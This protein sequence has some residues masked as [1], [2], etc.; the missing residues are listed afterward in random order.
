MHVQ[1]F[2]SS[3]QSKHVRL[4]RK[5][6]W[7][8]WHLQPVAT[9]A[10]ETVGVRWVLLVGREKEFCFNQRH[11][12]KVFDQN[13]FGTSNRRFWGFGEFEEVSASY[14]FYFAQGK[15]ILLLLLPLLLSSFFSSSLFSSFCFIQFC[16]FLLRMRHF[17]V[18]GIWIRIRD[19]WFCA[20]S[21]NTADVGMW[22]HLAPL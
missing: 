16:R 3:F 1:R 10:M 12:C 18:L 17:N 11:R 14:T 2:R 15:S 13:T 8:H 20:D 9:V 6:C 19:V 4:F 22:I 7:H 21:G 5:W